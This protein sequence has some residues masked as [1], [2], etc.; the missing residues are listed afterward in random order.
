MVD[1]GKPLEHEGDDGRPPS[2]SKRLKTT[3]ELKENENLLFR[4]LFFDITRPYQ[5]VS[6]T[7]V[8]NVSIYS[9]KISFLRI[10]ENDIY[11]HLLGHFSQVN[12]SLNIYPK[13][14]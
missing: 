12:Y 4:L 6:S 9:I 2:H 3:K 5:S 7:Y 13:A 8:C 11:G 1:A 10:F 14:I